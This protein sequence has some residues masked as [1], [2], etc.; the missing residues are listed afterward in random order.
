M[1]LVSVKMGIKQ[2]FDFNGTAAR[3]EF[4]FFMLF[5]L[6]L[7]LVVAIIDEATAATTIS[8]L[9]LPFGHLI[10]MGMV[11]PEVGLLVLLYRPIMAIPT[12]SATVRRLHDIGRSGWWALLWVLPIPVLGWLYLVPL[13]CQSSQAQP[14]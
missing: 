8:L 3:S 5:F 6:L 4:W 12:T 7:Y 10:P 9:D 1:F 11:D 13:L 2:S 14:T